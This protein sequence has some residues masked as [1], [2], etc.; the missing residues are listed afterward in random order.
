MFRVFTVPLNDRENPQEPSVPDLV[1][2]PPLPGLS[3]LGSLCS[4][5]SAAPS[6]SASQEENFDAL[7]LSHVSASLCT[8]EGCADWDTTGTQHTHNTDKG[9]GAKKKKG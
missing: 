9:G 1:V 8:G 5:S 4:A 3:E 2:P 6:T 7:L